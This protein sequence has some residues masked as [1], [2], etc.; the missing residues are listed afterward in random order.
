MSKPMLT[1]AEIVAEQGERVWRLVFRLLGNENDA[2][3][4]YQQTFLDAFR[5]DSTKVRN[6]E[7][8]LC[9][10]ASRRAMDTLRQ[11]YRTKATTLTDAAAT[12]RETPPDQQAT[13][14]ELREEVRKVLLT[15]PDHQATAFWL[16]HVEG[17]TPHEVSEQLDVTPG[18]VRV[19]VHRAIKRLRTD[20][21]STYVETGERHE[22]K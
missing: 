17:L 22:H 18:H 2:K 7:A 15:L 1:P 4:C 20:L 3:D 19:L 12:V 14:A 9:K 13:F 11:R 10:I 8:M 6:W 5:M 16:R 21:K